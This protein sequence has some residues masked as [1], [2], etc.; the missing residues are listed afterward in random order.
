MIITIKAV[1]SSSVLNSLKLLVLR[2]WLM[3]QTCKKEPVE[4][5]KRERK[6]QI[7]HKAVHVSSSQTKK[8][9]SLLFYYNSDWHF[10]L[11]DDS[12]AWQILFIF[13]IINNIIILFIII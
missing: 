6:G 13:T 8:K 1:S 3:K 2:E 7:L 11:T 10:D 12:A 5:Q 9:E 4:V